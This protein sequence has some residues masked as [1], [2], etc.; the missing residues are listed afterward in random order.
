MTKLC[1]DFITE[2][3]Q[4]SFT[5][6]IDSCVVSAVVTDKELTIS[7]DLQYGF[8][9][10][11]ISVTNISSP[12]VFTDARLDGVSF[13]QTLYTMFADKQCKRQTTTLTITDNILYLPFINPIAVWIASCA[14]K[15]P[16]KLYAHSLYDEF[17]IY[18]PESIVIPASFPKILQD[19]MLC[20]TDFYMHAK[21]L[22]LD[23]YYN[24]E[25]P[26]AKLSK[27]TYDDT[28]LY[29]ELFANLEFFKNNARTPAQSKYN[30]LE[31][32]KSDWRVFDF[33]LEKNILP[34]AQFPALYKLLHDLNLD[35]I[36]HGFIGILG[37]GEYITPHVD[38][39][40]G[41]EFIIEK[42]GGCGQLYIPVNFKE[43]NYFKFNNIGLVPLDGPMLINT[44]HFAHALINNSN[45]Y[46]FAIG[47][48]GSRLHIT[49]KD[50]NG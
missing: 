26:Y 11:A 20:N 37:P 25:V 40:E 50:D 14:E 1:L 7:A 23:P 27:L 8:H 3:T 9:T 16:A 46:R 43:G 49:N 5:V 30:K 28:A 19:Y 10:L 45:E 15:I 17:E 42:Y 44:Q 35:E 32:S 47:I 31:T 12:I 34:E 4:P 18:Y 21:S 22:L 38:R 29:T 33:I 48:H 6:L 36:L 13:R 39:Y 2:S 41:M 24:A